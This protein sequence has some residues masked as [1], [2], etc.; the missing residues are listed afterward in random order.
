MNPSEE[1]DHALRNLWAVDLRAQLVDAL[2]AMPAARDPQRRLKVLAPRAPTLSDD[3]AQP[4]VMTNPFAET[5]QL[6][7]EKPA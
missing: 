2:M 6:G 5:D 1:I 4:Y 7:T 3:F